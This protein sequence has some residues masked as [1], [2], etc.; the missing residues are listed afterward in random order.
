[1]SGPAPVRLSA[2][3]VRLTASTLPPVVRDRFRE[4][5]LADV[6]GSR[7]LGLP[8]SGV[9]WG[10]ALFSLTLNRAA[11]EVSG[12]PITE[13][14]HRRARWGIALLCSSVVWGMGS[15]LLGGV[16]PD[17]GA[18]PGAATVT[19]AALAPLTFLVPILAALCAVAGVAQLWR[20][21]FH[22]STLAIIT[23]ALATA[24]FTTAAA[25]AMSLLAS[26]ASFPLGLAALAAVLLLAALVC[27]L[28]TLAFA[29][30]RYAPVFPPPAPFRPRWHRRTVVVSIAAAL[31]GV[32]GFG[33]VDLLVWG[34][35][36]ATES[37]TVAE[38]Y[39]ALSPA[40][41]SAGIASIVVWAVFWGVL[42]LGWLAAAMFFSQKADVWTVRPVVTSALVVVSAAVFFQ[43]WAG[44]SLGMSIAD[45]IPPYSGGISVAGYLYALGGQ[46]ALAGAICLV[47]APRRLPALAAA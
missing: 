8:S 13:T 6:A 18:Q 45:T 24:G 33:A 34:P 31:L 10:A 29:P 42:V 37:L 4:E 43:F 44:F 23:A 1:M 22:A 47:V 20:A 26:S 14:V 25:L 17:G 5:W 12:L 32:V 2:A 11:P 35:L 21:A 19:T 36:S 16:R 9:V 30:A 41:R 28:A 27:G 3:L 39:A 46:L 38:I 15:F 7:E 40:D